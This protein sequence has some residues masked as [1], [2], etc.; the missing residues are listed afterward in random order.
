MCDGPHSGGPARC[1]ARRG[2]CGGQRGRG[3]ERA[4]VEDLADAFGRALGDADGDLGPVAL[5]ELDVDVVGLAR[6]AERL[7]V[8]APQGPDDLEVHRVGVG[9]R[10][11]DGAVHQHRIGA[12]LVDHAL[13]HARERPAQRAGDIARALRGEAGDLVD[14]HR[15]PLRRHRHLRMLLDQRVDC[16]GDV[17][18][19]GIPVDG[20][21]ARLD[22]AGVEAGGMVGDD[23]AVRAAHLDGEQRL[24]VGRLAGD[25]A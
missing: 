5:E 10:D 7:A 20:V 6:L 2:R 25:A 1:P 8:G 13:A 17:L 23:P 4:L 18:R 21:R 16:G 14:H 24:A 3:R 15:R 12:R 19:Q 22:L 9:A 11:G